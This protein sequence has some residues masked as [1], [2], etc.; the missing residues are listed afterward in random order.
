MSLT[1]YGFS[2]AL[3]VAASLLL[4][5]VVRTMARRWNLVAKPRADRWHRKPT[6]LFG[7]VAIF[8]AFVAAFLLRRPVGAAGGTLLV[9]CASGMFVL[10][11]IDDF[12]QLKPY[13]KLVGQIVVS[14][15]F[16]TY[17]LRLHWLPAP[18]ADQVLTIFWLVGITNALNLLDNL[19]GLAGGVAAIAAAFLVYFCDASGNNGSAVLAAAF[20]GALVGF[21]V[22]NFNP[23][24]IFMGDCGSLF[25]GF[26]LAGITMVNNQHA[27]R[28]NVMAVLTIPVLLLMIPIVDTALVTFSR[29]LHGRPVSQ[30]GRDHTSHRLVALGLSERRAALVLWLFAAASGGIA[31]VVRNLTWPVASLIV[32]LFAMGVLFLLIFVGRVRTY[33]SIEN[34]A[35]VAGRALLPTLADFSYKRRVFEVLNDLVLIV[36]AF[37]GAFLLRFD[38]VLV[39]PFYSQLVRALPT[40]IVTQIAAFLTLGLYN[41]LW[42]YTSVNDLG[43]VLKA[44]GGGWIASVVAVMFLFRFEAFSRGMFVVD[45]V[46]LTLAVAGTR[47]S[48]RVLRTWLGRFQS[49][50][51]PNRKRVLIYGA[52][53]A[54]EL[55]V[56]ELQNNHDL[57]LLPVGFLDDDPQKVGRMIHGV[58]VL[59]AFERLSELAQNEHVDEVVIST[60]KLDEQR[61]AA[62]ATLCQTAGVACRQMR[63]SLE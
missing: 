38:G 10:G 31:V 35:E 32:A 5:L 57:G 14:A 39:E 29:K 60:V 61:R 51:D 62:L 28:S 54:G 56:R 45:L 47:V 34:A 27:M 33:T 13:A 4:T 6:A 50:S 17:G 2:F 42:R 21:L 52:G 23:A 12:V 37:Y 19:D 49:E 40:I 59:G 7:G 44:V 25:L 24:S 3:A 16:T 36:L 55:L 48:F 26:F 18:I 22:F 1:Q 46:L 53:D 15:I 63:I 11:L 8:G 58:R 30:G 43:T 9:I 20:C 41:G